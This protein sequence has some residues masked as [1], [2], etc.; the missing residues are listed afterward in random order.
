MEVG[1]TEQTL[2]QSLHEIHLQTQRSFRRLLGK[3]GHLFALI[4]MTIEHLGLAARN[5]KRQRLQQS[6]SFRFRCRTCKRRPERIHGK[7]IQSVSPWRG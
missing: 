1:V 5:P 3:V 6:I 2:A 7:F 4:T